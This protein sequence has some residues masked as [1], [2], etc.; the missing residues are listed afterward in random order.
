MINFF[1]NLAASLIPIKLITKSYNPIILYHSIGLN[2]KFKNNIDHVSLQ[3]LIT[4]LKTIQKFWKFVPID[5]YVEI[6]N[7]KGIASLT[8]DDGYKNIIDEALEVFE[9]L[10]IPITI[11][12]N[13]STFKGK[14][15]WRDKVRYL[16][17]NKKVEKFINN[18]N[19]FEK[20][21]LDKFYSISKSPIYNS[22]E[23]ENEI[24]KFLSRENIKIN[25]GYEFCFD[26]NDYLIKHPL[27]SYGNHTANHYVL[28]SLTKEQQYDEIIECKNYID[29][30][31]INKSKVFSIPFGGNKSFNSDTLL[32]L[33]DLNYKTILKCTNDLDSIYSSNEI[34]RFMPKTYKI[35][36]TLK[37]M[38]LKKMLKR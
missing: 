8:I 6:K 36:N 13:S 31:N 26:S 15:F 12:I 4:Q 21:H 35:E 18:S 32:N 20:K 14:I 9:N 1:K 7:K 37:K 16:I 3:I 19:L 17:D 29:K 28:S 23:V 10:K 27:I 22:I 30:M 5:E 2:S 24:D 34:N 25:N 33:D 11:F 38:Y